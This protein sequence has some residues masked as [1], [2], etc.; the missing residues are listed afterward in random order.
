MP[1]DRDPAIGV[2]VKV[3]RRVSDIPE[4]DRV[5]VL[6]EMLALSEDANLSATARSV[7]LSIWVA[8][9][10]LLEGRSAEDD[11][12]GYCAPV[13]ARREREARRGER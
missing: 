1:P 11:L 6:R 8:V 4:G 10:A 9:S 5:T 13:L 7:A 12:L 2:L 3:A